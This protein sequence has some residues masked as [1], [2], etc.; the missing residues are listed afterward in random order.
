[1]KKLALA[2]VCL[3]SV[4]FF[5]SCDPEPVIENPEP[6]IAVIAEDG[7]L[8]DGATIDVNE[9]RPY[10]FIV[11]SNP[12]TQA[13]LSKFVVVCNDVILCDTTITGTEFTYRSEIFFEPNEETR[14]YLGSA[15][16]IAT[17][18]DVNGKSNKA[19]I[20]IDIYEPDNLVSLPFTWTREG[21]NDGQGLDIYGLKW[22]K[23]A[24]EVFA[25]IEP[26]DGVTLY[27]IPAAEWD[28]TLTQ[29]DKAAL[30]SEGG[31]ATPIRDYRGVSAWA[32]HQYNDVIATL[33]DG[34]YY[35]MHITKAEVSTKGTNI[36]IYGEVK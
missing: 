3:V 30:F 13:E 27:E 7:Y 28:K 26:L 19:M 14:E 15:E 4:A 23:N 29:A 2:L 24:K 25:V 32:S 33:Y 1:M 18:T 16:I 17:V 12:E 5:A 11:A 21:G 31:A 36:I 22:T 9:V 35:M 34:H 10:G 8:T 20:K 6:S